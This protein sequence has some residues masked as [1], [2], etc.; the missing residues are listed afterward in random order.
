MIDEH[1]VS[2]RGLLDSLARNSWRC[3]LDKLLL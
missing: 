3:A 1:I 2:F